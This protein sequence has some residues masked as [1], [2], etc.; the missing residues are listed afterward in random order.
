MNGML[1]DSSMIKSIQSGF[2]SNMPIYSGIKIHDSGNFDLFYLSKI[3]INP[4]NPDKCILLLD[5]TRTPSFNVISSN[6]PKD[7][8]VS[9]YDIITNKFLSDTAET[10][11]IPFNVNIEPTMSSLIHHDYIGIE[12]YISRDQLNTKYKVN[13]DFVDQKYNSN[14][15]TL[16]FEYDVSNYPHA[17]D[18]SDTIVYGNHMIR[19]YNNTN[20]SAIFNLYQWTLI[21]FK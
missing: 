14:R 20:N 19:L 2:A 17:A 5:N 3:D 9:I 1:T 15:Y 18:S 8:D 10:I 6:E 12:Y 11:S 13:G 7:I 21:E 4:V 16:G